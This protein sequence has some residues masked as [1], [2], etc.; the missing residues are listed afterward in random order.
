[1]IRKIIAKLA[2]SGFSN[3]NQDALEKTLRALML[4]QKGA[5]AIG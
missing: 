2:R 3:R 4:N 1:M 5:A